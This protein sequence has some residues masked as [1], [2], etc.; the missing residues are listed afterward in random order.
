[1]L[2]SLERKLDETTGPAGLEGEDADLES[3]AARSASLEEQIL[4]LEAALRAKGIGPHQR[5]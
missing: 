4:D 1:M 2:R 3:L 5:R